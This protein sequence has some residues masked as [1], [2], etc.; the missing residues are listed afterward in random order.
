MEHKKSD[1]ITFFGETNFRNQSQQFGI[2]IDDRRRH[3]YVIGKT[4]MGKTTLLE[5]MAASDIL[6]GHG[7]AI[8]DPHGEFA[9][10]MLEFV[11]KNRINDVIYFNPG[12]LDYPIALNVIEQVD[13]EYRHLVASGLIGVFK[14]IWADSWGPRLEYLLRNAIL[15]LLEYPGATLLGIMRILIDKEYRKKVVAKVSDPVV[16]GF[17]VDEFSKYPD[18]FQSEAVAPIQNKVGQFLTSSLIRNIVGQTKSKIDI[19]EVMDSRKILIMNLAKGRLGEDNSALLG[20]MMITRIQLAAM[21]RVDIPEE[22]RADFFLYVDEFQNFA[23]ESFASILSEARKYRLSL[24]LAH[25]YIEQVEE[26]VRNAVFGNVGTIVSFRVGAQDA[27]FLET[28]FAP[29]FMPLDLV[30]L[31]KFNIYLK[32]MIDGV[33][34]RPFSSTTLPPISKPGKPQTKKIIQIS[35]ERYASSRK[36]VEERISRWSLTIPQTQNP[37]GTK[38]PYAKKPDNNYKVLNSAPQ[39]ATDPAEEKF[40]VNCSNCGRET[41]VK[42]KPDGVRPTY[43]RECLQLVKKGE[44]TAIPAKESKAEI[45]TLKKDEKKASTPV[46]SAVKSTPK[47]STEN[48]TASTPQKTSVSRPKPLPNHQKEDTID[49]QGLR[50]AIEKAKKKD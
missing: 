42:F 29:E 10:K 34:C 26:T 48:K 24:I 50:D 43:C 22:E 1:S 25:Q 21:G 16:K 4:G 31:T 36:Q 9:E 15:A 13:P 3:M 2:K 27:E 11:P 44:I 18:R 33:A 8:V 40:P 49:V 28:E 7:L 32:L 46:K 6:N 17:W 37:P 39:K 20:A 23:T 47:T 41:H 19:R 45:L 12:D 30:N 35:R 38:N 5:N 14:K